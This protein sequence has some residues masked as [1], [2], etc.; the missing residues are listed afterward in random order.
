MALKLS[1]ARLLF[2]V[3]TERKPLAAKLFE[4]GEMRHL[5]LWHYILFDDQFQSMHGLECSWISKVWLGGEFRVFEP[6][7][8][9]GPDSIGV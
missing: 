4:S 6:G 8:A 5:L 3:S 2:Q 1:I 7:G 9:N